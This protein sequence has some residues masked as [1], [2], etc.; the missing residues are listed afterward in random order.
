MNVNVDEHKHLLNM[1]MCHENRNY[2][3]VKTEH[4]PKERKNSQLHPQYQLSLTAREI[5]CIISKT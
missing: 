4:R 5:L 1:F 3:Q 2:T